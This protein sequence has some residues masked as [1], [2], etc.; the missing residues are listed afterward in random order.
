MLSG[1]PPAGTDT[2]LES[3]GESPPF[4]AELS[5]GA[6]EPKT[7][8]AGVTGSWLLSLPSALQAGSVDNPAITISTPAA[9]WAWR[10]L[11]GRGRFIGRLLGGLGAQTT[12]FA[13][14]ADDVPDAGQTQTLGDAGEFSHTLMR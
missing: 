1:V 14:S 11:V 6:T 13:G 7:E 9:R 3:I 2:S 5:T 12:V 8:P 4:T 10:L